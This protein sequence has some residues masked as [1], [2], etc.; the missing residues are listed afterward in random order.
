MKSRHF[1]VIFSILLLVG[2]LYIGNPRKIADN[3]G[4]VE[5]WYIPLVLVLYFINVL[6]KN[7]RWGIVLDEKGLFRKTLP[8]YVMGLAVNSVTPGRVGGEPFRA[9]LL[10]RNT[11][12]RFGKG[13]ASVFTEKIMDIIVL[14]CFSIVGLSFLVNELET[15]DLLKISLQLGFMVFLLVFI[16]YATF[17]PTLLERI[18]R[19]LIHVSRRISNHHYIDFFERK[20]VSIISNFKESLREFTR[21]RKNATAGFI[22]TTVI[23]VN[24]AARLYLIL[25][26][27]DIDAPLG[28]VIIASSIAAIAGGI[29]PGGVGNA[30]IITII[31]SAA[32][33]TEA[34]ATTAGIIMVLTS[35]WISIPLGMLSSF[36]CKIDIHLSDLIEK[37]DSGVGGEGGGGNDM[38]DENGIAGKPPPDGN[39][40]QETLPGNEDRV[41]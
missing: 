10:N 21:K 32:E 29:L 35:I 5:L 33:I 40:H 39:T 11:S 20:L 37:E 30:A 36:L 17:H 16:L 3:L 14:T 12:C 23:W 26:A 31:L 15:N 6:T 4:R 25:R 27:M 19:R 22:L 13:V 38:N 34:Q 2:L 9:Y 24:E 1:S 7:L 8:L 18:A 28:A 41:P